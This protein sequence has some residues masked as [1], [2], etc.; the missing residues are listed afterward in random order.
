MIGYMPQRFGLY[1]D[2][3]VAENLALF[4]RSPRHSPRRADPARAGCSPSPGS[5]RSRRASPASSPAHEAEARPRLRPARPAPRAPPRRTPRSGRSGLAAGALGDRRRD[6]RGGPRRGRHERDLGDRLSR[7]GG[8]LRRR[9]PAPRG[10]IDRLRPARPAGRVPRGPRLPHRRAVGPPARR[11]A[12]GGGRSALPRCG[13]RGRS[14]PPRA[15]RRHR[16]AG[17]R[18][19]GGTA[20]TPA[21]PRFEDASSPL[22]RRADAA[23]TPVAP[24][25][26]AA[27]SP[28][29]SV[30]A[31]ETGPAIEVDDLV[32]TFGDFVAV[33]HVSFRV[34]RG[35]IFG[36]LGPNGA[37]K[38]TAFRML[39]GL[40]KPSGGRAR[41]AGLDL[42]VAPAKARARIATWRNASRSIPS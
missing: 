13:D 31:T 38:S 34:A 19:F 29:P 8:A 24:P 25:P 15:A 4:S 37:G 40:L 21:A 35:E 18:D 2:L 20:A 11:P 3:S 32:R 41:V 27:P 7:R 42:L 16:P 23:E 1:E 5:P 6:A 39:C 26:A 9:A 17:A 10:Q 33:D 14:P 12:P 36:L 28:A 22:L 30:P